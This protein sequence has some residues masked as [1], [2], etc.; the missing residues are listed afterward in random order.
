MLLKQVLKFGIVCLFMLLALDSS[1]QD[2]IY[3]TPSNPTITKEHN[4]YFDFTKGKSRLLLL[5]RNVVEETFFEYDDIAYNLGFEF[6]EKQNFAQYIGLEYRF[7]DRFALQVEFGR[8]VFASKYD[9]LGQFDSTSG[10]RPTIRNEAAAH[11]FTLPVTAKFR[12]YE[13]GDEAFSVYALPSV[14]FGFLQKGYRKYNISPDMNS[15]VW[16]EVNESD[17]FTSNLVLGSIGI[18]FNSRI[19]PYLYLTGQARFMS[20]LNDINDGFFLVGFGSSSNT[21]AI[22]IYSSTGQL[23]LGVQVRLW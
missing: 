5:Q 23:S 13:A 11:Y 10:Q 14:Y 16:I 2:D 6:R 22:P 17:G 12:L 18:E 3:I 15:G 19:L 1:A 21:V 9:Y 8:N 20:S 7:S 4:S